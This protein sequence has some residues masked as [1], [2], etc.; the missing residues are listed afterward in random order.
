MAW[1][2][3]SNTD[4]DTLRIC[5]FATLSIGVS[6]KRL[7]YLNVSS[8]PASAHSSFSISSVSKRSGRSG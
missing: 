6:T 1:Q 7:L 3:S 5:S 2:N 8:T 4:I